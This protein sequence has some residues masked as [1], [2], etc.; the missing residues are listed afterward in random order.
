MLVSGPAAP[1]RTLAV[2][3]IVADEPLS[4]SPRSHLTVE[5]TTVQP[6]C[7]AVAVT[8]EASIPSGR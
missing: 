5:P 3:V 7:E 2:I 6:P 1:S 8:E 4:S